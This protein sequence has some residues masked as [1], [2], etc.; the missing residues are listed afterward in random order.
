[1]L[2]LSFNH[3]RAAFYGCHAKDPN[4]EMVQQ[5]LKQGLRR[6]RCLHK[7][8]PQ[9]IVTWL[10]AEHNRH[11]KGSGENALGLVQEALAIESSWRKKCCTDSITTRHPSYQKLYDSFVR[12]ESNTFKESIT[13]FGES[14]SLGHA[15]EQWDI[16][17]AFEATSG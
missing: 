11:H 6:C 12:K 16:Y 17:K 7:N 5:T 10:C 4:H 13:L 15:L 9:Y 8:T 14:K 3:R 1:L 2:A